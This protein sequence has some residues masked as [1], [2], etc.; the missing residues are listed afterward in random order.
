MIPLDPIAQRIAA[1][2][3]RRAVRVDALAQRLAAF[4]TT[5]TS[6]ELV[7]APPEL[8]DHAAGPPWRRR[9]VIS[10]IYAAPRLRRLAV[11]DWSAN[12]EDGLTLWAEATGA[13][14]VLVA[15]LA[16]RGGALRGYVDLLGP[17]PRDEAL[18]R[19][20]L[21]PGDRAIRF[22]SWGAREPWR[23]PL[24][25]PG[26]LSLPPGP[27]EIEPIA[28]AL[29]TVCGRYLRW[30]QGPGEG[31]AG[32]PSARAAVLAAYLAGGRLPG[33]A[34]AALGKPWADRLLRLMIDP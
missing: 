4:L 17:S 26:A 10:R 11:V 13:A 1:A 33:A 27:E 6:L 34:A 5:L 25:A 2:R 7:P 9:R 8:A 24:S 28:E 20:V 21:P 31:R 19:A 12:G 18:D 22:P 32:S 29:M 14:P 23:I 15:E 30:A 3:L 16:A